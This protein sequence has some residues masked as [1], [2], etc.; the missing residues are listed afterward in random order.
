MKNI[1]NE[2][3]REKSRNALDV[4]V[5]V[6]LNVVNIVILNWVTSKRSYRSNGVGGILREIRP[7]AE[8]C[9]RYI[10]NAMLFLAVNFIEVKA[11]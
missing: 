10:F 8:A 6:T 1:R 9:L 3:K 5:K 11:R 4:L 7:H 2:L